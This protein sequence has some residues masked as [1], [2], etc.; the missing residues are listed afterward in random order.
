MAGSGA[1]DRWPGDV[2]APLQVRSRLAGIDLRQAGVA[3]VVAAS[4]PGAVLLVGAGLD[5]A[6]ER[7]A[8]QGE[9]RFAGAHR[10]CCLVQRC[11]DF[12]RREDQWQAGAAVA[13]DHEARGRRRGESEGRVASGGEGKLAHR[14]GIRA[15]VADGERLDRVVVGRLGKAE[16]EWKPAPRAGS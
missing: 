9:A 7:D 13:G 12:R 16:E 1:I 14:A 11:V 2:D 3:V 6:R 10:Q 4:G 15:G 5:L 8:E